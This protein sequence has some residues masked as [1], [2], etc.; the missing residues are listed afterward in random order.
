[1][2][3]HASNA[4][5]ADLKPAMG[6]CRRCLHCLSRCHSSFAVLGAFGRSLKGP[7]TACCLLYT[8]PSPR[9]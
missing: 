6:S 9:D 2:N 5:F 1:M 8:S 3:Q 7:D 4:A